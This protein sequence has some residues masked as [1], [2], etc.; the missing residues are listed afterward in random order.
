MSIKAFNNCLY[1]FSDRKARKLYENRFF[2]VFYESSLNSRDLLRASNDK[3]NQ[4]SLRYC[5]HYIEVSKII[6]NK[7]KEA[8][9]H[10]AQ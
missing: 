7:F 3:S 9:K 5:E 4:K 10:I 2:Y 8:Q 1:K 6:L